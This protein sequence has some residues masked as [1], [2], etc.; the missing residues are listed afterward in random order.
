MIMNSKTKT[1]IIMD[2]VTLYSMHSSTSRH[3]NYNIINMILGPCDI[4]NHVTLSTTISCSYMIL[5]PCHKYIKYIKIKTPCLKIYCFENDKRD[6]V[7]YNFIFIYM[8][9]GPCHI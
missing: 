1:K 6:H 4:T 2:L 5:G 7:D 3:V 8:I 9:L